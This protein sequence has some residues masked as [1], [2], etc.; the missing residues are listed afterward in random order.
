MINLLYGGNEY[1][2]KGMVISFLS[3]VKHTKCPI[4]VYFLTMD[5]RDIN[6]SYIPPTEEEFA[7]LEKILKK[8]NEENEI[9]VIDLSREFREQ[10]LDG[11]NN[12]H[13]YATPY[14]MLRL[15]IDEIEGLP[16]KLLYLDSDTIINSDLEPFYNIDISDYD[17]ACCKDA[18][19]WGSPSRWRFAHYFNA[20]VL[21][22]NLKRLKENGRIRDARN[23]VHDKKMFYV[24]QQALN[25]AI[26]DK[27]F[28]GEKYNE[29]KKYYPEVVVQHFCSVRK[30]YGW[31][32]IKPWEVSEVKKKMSAY[33]DILDEYEKR[34]KEL[35]Q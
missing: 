14:T 5:L 16:D 20:G 8:G 24:D 7:Y 35:G 13:A 3:L 1:I 27:L 23:L 11:V 9:T 26:K 15:F 21:L 4:H 34:M 25:I 2:F 22:I 19:N 29:K 18:N 33:N 6:P 30:K 31:R 17:I 28:L 10:M 12:G 32:Y